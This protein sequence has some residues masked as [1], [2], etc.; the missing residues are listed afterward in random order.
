MDLFPHRPEMIVL[1]DAVDLSDPRAEEIDLPTH[2]RFDIPAHHLD[3]GSIDQVAIGSGF[4]FVPHFVRESGAGDQLKTQD[5]HDMLVR[6]NTGYKIS[7]VLRLPFQVPA[8]HPHL[9]T[10]ALISGDAVD[11]GRLLDSRNLDKCGFDGLVVP[12]QLTVGNGQDHDVVG[13]KPKVLGLDMVHLEPDDH[14]SGHQEYGH[15]K[16]EDDQHTTEAEST[17]SG[18]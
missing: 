3:Q 17:G 11:G 13:F 14:G 7:A 4:R 6:R 5:I 9:I 18:A 12:S 2:R 10:C 8:F 15:G 1:V 16:L